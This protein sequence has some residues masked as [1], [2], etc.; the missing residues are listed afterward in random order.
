M[1][2]PRCRCRLSATLLPICAFWAGL[3]A[4]AVAQGSAASDRAVLET[5]YDATGGPDWIDNTNWK[6]ASPL[7]EW[8]GVTTD[9]AGRVT[10]LELPGNGLAGP[11]PAALGELPLL[12]NLDLGSRWDST[13]QRSVENRL[14]GSIPAELENLANLEWLSLWNNALTGP[15]PSWLGRLT[16]LRSLGLG[17]NELAGP[18]PAELGN[19]ANLERLTIGWNEVTGP[20]PSWLGRLT[21]LRSLDLSGNGLTGPL[22]AELGRLTSLRSLGLSG[23]GLTGP[24]PV[25]LGNLVNLEWLNLENNALTGPVPS[26]LGRL[27]SLWSLD[28]YGNELAGPLPAELGRLT[29]LR[30]LGLSGNGLTGPLPAE[31][32]N[33]ANLE[34]LYL[35]SNPLAGSLPQGLTRLSQLRTLDISYTGACAPANAEFQ[36]WLETIADFRGDTCNRSPESV[37]TIPPQVLTESGP[38]VGVSMDG[39][40]TDPDDD[41]LT[42]TAASGQAGTVTA[43]ASGD[44]VWLVPGSA[45]SATV[46][47]TATDPGGLSATQIIAVTVN[48]L[49]EP[50]NDREVLEVLYDSTGGE[51]WTNRNN[52]KTSAPL[53]EWYG[54]TTDTAGRV[55][56]LD[57]GGNELTGPIPAALGDLELLQDL[58]LADRWDPTSQQ[59][60]TNAL[61]GPI[62][63][64]LG[65]L[66]HLRQL[67]LGDNALTGRIPDALG[68]LTNLEWLGLRGN[69][70]TGSIPSSLGR[71]SNLTSLDLWGNELTGRIP[72]ALGNLTNLE[73][74]GLGGNELTGSIPSSL[75][76]L[77]N[78]TSLDL[79]GNELTGR[80]PDALGNLAN[81]ESLLL[82][83][84]G[85]TGPIPAA[86]GR[87]SNLRRL[88]FWHSWGLSGPLPGG[89]ESSSLEELGIFATQICAPTVW[90]DWL[91]TIEF[92]GR[93]CEVEPEFTIDVAVFY[94]SAAREEAGGAAEIEAVIDL[95]VADTNEAYQASGV[96]HR[97]ELVARSEVQYAE[98]GDFRDIGRLANPSDGYMDEVHAIRDRTGA[99][100]VHLIFNY[101]EHPFSGVAYFGGAF[102]LTCQDCG[103]GTFAHELG[104]NMGLR[105]DRYAQ[106]YS[107]IGRGP[108]TLDPAFGYVNQ[109]GLAVSAARSRRWV[110][111]MSYHTQ[112]SDTY[113]RCSELLRFS[114]PRQS[115]NGDP[116]G[117]PF[118]SGGSGVTGA[119]DAA[120]VLNATGPAVALWRDH[121]LRPNRPPEAVGTLPD[122]RLALGGMVDLDVSSAFVDPDLGDVLT[123]TVSSSSPQVVTARI[124]GARVTVTAVGE[125]TAPV[126]VTATDPGGLSAMQTFT[127]TVSPPSNRPPEPVGVLP[128]V[129]LGVDDSALTV[130]V[131]AAFRDPDGDALTYGATTSSP[132]VVTVLAAGARVTVTAVGEGTAPVTVTATD[133]GGLSAMQTFTVT[134]SPP[135]NRPPEPVGVLP[136]VTLGVD[137]SA[138]TVDV[139]AAFRDPDGDALT[140]GATTSSPAVVTVLAAGARVTVTAVGEGTAPVTVT[141]TDPGGLSAMQTFTV[142]VSPPS[143]RPPEPV[144]V[145]PAVTLGVDDSALTVD[146]AAA[147]RDPDGDALTYGATTSS[148]AVVTVLAAGARVT[149]TAV[150]EGTAPVTVTATDPGGLSAM[151]TF[152]VT[153]SPPSNRPP[154]PVGVL[155]AVTLGVDDSALT[156]DVAAA[157]RDPDGDVLTYRASSSAPH[158]VTARAVDSR[159]TLAAVDAGTATAEVTATDPDG[160]S[161][162]QSFRVRV[163][164]PFTDDPIVPG[165]TPVRAVHFTEL[166]ARI[167]VLRQEA[168]LAPFAWT[169]PALRA[170]VTPVR[171]THLLELRAAVAAA[172]ASAGRSAP[173]WTDAAPSAGTT[174][175]RAAHL[176]ELRAAVLALE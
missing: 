144:G 172:Y 110:T 48:A 20:V 11:I 47:V 107:E 27:T 37:D 32:G 62:P 6:G 26:W 73:W 104:H 95:M 85:L 150:G 70:L 174:P 171:L 148:P 24:L 77:S 162:V 126:T 83:N 96:H 154:E 125:G 9:T 128:A 34:G 22:P 87:L 152:T 45:G 169:G 163:T 42:Y 124:A 121:V 55:T 117:V 159:V 2:G 69:E 76:R 5:L 14:T 29:S 40:F 59:W 38:A 36:A 114:N 142:T 138:L 137:D 64:E 15:V 17:G 57:L 80:I 51:S 136:A 71:L 82:G 158:V 140:Y 129:T 23:N 33:L 19:L 16:S 90:G 139:A 72:D 120:A 131:A 66:D 60:F 25:E 167:D 175:I 105:H 132:A 127:V 44:T 43:L 63:D 141:A 54:V 101:Q 108:V 74:L 30:S 1:S 113:A 88:D 8:F 123:Y 157:F 12:R 102:G 78:L 58:N 50:Q 56:E 143:N 165:E 122:R 149:V 4:E 61:I 53:G 118:G 31:L 91:D 164:A 75:G 147:F 166:R 21:S 156:V 173:P 18:L 93:L 100:L 170:G 65:R 35:S 133:P 146:V 7:G 109:P 52:W 84:N 134:V 135:S 119:A 151:Q 99:D 97:L 10:R 67:S 112:C 98:A 94:T 81:L 115:Y 103:G 89:L 145:L 3:A 68:N 49:A 106:L 39:Y 86:L 168:G 155:P 92:E 160:L 13:A 176:M 116:L 161:A 111:I 79:W 46:T 153:V 130:D 28:L 41:P